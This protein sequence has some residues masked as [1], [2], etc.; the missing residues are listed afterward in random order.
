MQQLWLWGNQCSF[1]FFPS[2]KFKM[3]IFIA[4]DHRGFQMKNHLKKKFPN[5]KWFDLGCDSVDSVDYPDYADKL[6]LHIQEKERGILI[7]GSGQGMAM[8]ANKYPHI[9][10]AL[11]WNEQ[12]TT[13][14]R[15]HNDSNVLCL[16]G[17]FTSLGLCEKITQ[18]FFD[19]K[20]LGQRHEK[21][22]IKVS[23]RL[24]CPT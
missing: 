12:V 21:R 23:K 22:V 24:P 16:G 20:F 10:A 5:T 2:L 8:R 15:Q 6:A 9:R 1:N 18:I 7:C 17:Q 19:T 13:L 14:S 3:H 11:C 4:C